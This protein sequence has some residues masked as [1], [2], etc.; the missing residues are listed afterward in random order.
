MESQKERGIIAWM[1]DSAVAADLLLMVVMVGGLA[2]LGGITK[3]VFP[4]IR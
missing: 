1:A 2:S 4:T 3:E